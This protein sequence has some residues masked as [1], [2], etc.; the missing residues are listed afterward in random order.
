MKIIICLTV[1]AV[2][3]WFFIML[4][5]LRTI[6]DSSGEVVRVKFKP[7]KYYFIFAGFYIAGEFYR[8]ISILKKISRDEWYLIAGVILSLPRAAF[9]V[10]H[11]I[12][13]YFSW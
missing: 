9:F 11:I 5:I 3:G 2:L 13:K 4:D 10:W 7:L 8:I 6:V 12:H 1:L